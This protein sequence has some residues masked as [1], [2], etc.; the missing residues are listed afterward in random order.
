M[1]HLRMRIIS[2]NKSIMLLRWSP[3]LFIC[4]SL[5]IGNLFAYIIDSHVYHLGMWIIF[6][7][8]SI[9]LLRWAPYILLCH[10]SHSLNLGTFCSL[11]FICGEFGNAPNVVSSKKFQKHF[12]MLNS[13]RYLWLFKWLELRILPNKHCMKCQEYN[14]HFMVGNS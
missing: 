1:Y 13:K 12:E 7:N 9:M 14:H 6:M 4:H 5:S 2:I 8:K 11:E 10:S 3:Y